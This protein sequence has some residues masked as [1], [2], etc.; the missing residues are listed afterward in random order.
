MLSC[1]VD[2]ENLQLPMLSLEL[3]TNIQFRGSD[4]TILVYLRHLELL[5]QAIRGY[6]C[7]DLLNIH[8]P[9]NSI[10][11]FPIHHNDN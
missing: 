5:L 1:I 6:Q 3:W 11:N 7:R 8:F 2:T 9:G 4:R 10:D